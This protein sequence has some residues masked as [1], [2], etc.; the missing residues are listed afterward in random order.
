MVQVEYKTKWTT[1]LQNLP[2]YFQH[3]NSYN[4]WEQQLIHTV[5]QLY[6]Y[7]SFNNN[8][9]NVLSKIKYAWFFQCV[10]TADHKGKTLQYY[11]PIDIDVHS[12]NTCTPSMLK[13]F[14]S[15]ILLTKTTSI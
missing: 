6:D 13:A 2:A 8:K 5:H 1:P 15:T 14:V 12:V 9:Y 10:E 7:M 4:V 11:R 3:N